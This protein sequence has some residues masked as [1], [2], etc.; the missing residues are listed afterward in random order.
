MGRRLSEYEAVTCY[1]QPDPTAFDKEG[2][3]LRTTEGRVAWE[4][5]ST[6]LAH[7]HWF[8]FR[9][10]AQQWQRTYVRM[11]AEQ[12]R[13]IERL[14]Q[15]EAANGGIRD[16]D[17]IWL[18]QIVQK[19]YRVWSYFE[20]AVFRAFAPAQREALSDT[21][22]NVLCFEAVDR[23]RHAQAI[24]IYLME[25]EDNIDGFIDH[26]SKDIWLTDPIYQPLRLLAE[27]LMLENARLGR[28]WIRHQSR[29]RSHRL[30]DRTQPT[31]AT[32][33]AVSWG[34]DYTVHHR[35]C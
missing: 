11:Q 24:V 1:A 34:H 4:Q 32:L 33:R 18:D 17:P 3:F 5:S 22:G 23:V 12:E 30:R 2:W 26:G 13:S 19:H 7:P 8:D 6:A 10:P 20:Y 28:S 25:L 31:G 21:L 9:D 16:M 35:N 29:D 27:K 15:D 14:C